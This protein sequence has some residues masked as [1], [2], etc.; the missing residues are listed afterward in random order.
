ME[1]L[2]HLTIK[3]KTIQNYTLDQGATF[4]KTVGAENSSSSVAVDISAGTVSGSI[5]KNYAYANTLRYISL[6]QLDRSK[7][8]NFPD[9]NTDRS[10]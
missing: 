1:V 10:T 8:H 6:H 2:W 5:I 3:E 7:H 9:R 4:A